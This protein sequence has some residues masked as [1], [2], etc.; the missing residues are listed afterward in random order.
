M[1]ALCSPL[2]ID[3]FRN[4]LPVVL[5]YEIIEVAVENRLD[6]ALL[7]TGAMVFDKLVGVHHIRHYLTPPGYLFFLLMPLGRL[8]R[9]F[10]LNTLV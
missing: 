5:D 3:S 7:D 2:L 4:P 8:A 6:V 10:L 9:L 1:I